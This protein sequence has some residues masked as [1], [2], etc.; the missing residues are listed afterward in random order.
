[1]TMTHPMSDRRA[2]EATRRQGLKEAAKRNPLLG[3]DA[4][5]VLNREQLGSRKSRRAPIAFRLFFFA[6]QDL[7]GEA[8]VVDLS[9][10][11]CKADSKTELEVGME[12]KLSLFMPDQ[13][14]AL[15]IERATVRWVHGYTFGVEFLTVL[16]AQRDRL[17]LLIAKHKTGA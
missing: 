12:L 5:R 8:W 2:V 3:V 1:M 14:W 17:R 6:E 7:E 11:G 10:T 13:P 15:R 9:T 16:P 4:Q